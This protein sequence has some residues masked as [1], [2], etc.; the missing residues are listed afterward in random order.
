MTPLLTVQKQFVNHCR[1][2]KSLAVNTARAYECDLSDFSSF[3]GPS[4]SASS[5]RPQDIERYIQDIRLRRALSAATAKRRLGCLKVFF[6]WLFNSGQVETN[7]LASL[8]LRI[9]MPRRLPRTIS[10]NELSG[11]LRATASSRDMD[12]YP[13]PDA[14]KQSN[15]HLAL[16]IMITTGVR[17]SELV[18]IKLGDIDLS[19]GRI[20]IHGKGSRERTVYVVNAKIQKRLAAYVKTR[21]KHES[22]DVHLFINR[23]GGHLTTATV[24]AYLKTAAKSASIVKRITPHMLRHT[25]ATLLIEEGVDIR[26]VQRLLGHQSISTTELY[27]HVTEVSL[28]S[29]LVRADFIGHFTLAG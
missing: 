20:R 16:L 8:S 22:E 13:N 19:E 14:S 4:T 1:Y 25:A 10:R 7:P 24:R 18:N 17:V 3:I 28:R 5:I 27:T 12:E 9:Q 29:A 15:T 6:A 23:N 26:F 2:T 21:A 11:L